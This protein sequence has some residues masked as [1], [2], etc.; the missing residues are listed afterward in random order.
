MA[1]KVSDAVLEKIREA[2]G[3]SGVSDNAEE[4]KPH[5]SEWRNRWQGETPLLI[6]PANTQEVSSV[7]RICSDTN[8]PIVPQ[9][10]NTG[11]VGGQIPTQGE[12]LLSLERMNKIREIW[13]GDNIISVEAGAVL[14]EVQAAAERAGRLFPLSLAAEGSCTIGGNLSTNAGGTNV[15]RY[16]NA[17][18]LVLGLEVVLADGAIVEMMRGLRKDN[19]GYDLKQ[20]FIGAEGTLGI[21]TAAMLKLYPKI[22][23]YT[24]VFASLSSV[25]NSVEL[26]N[27]IQTSVGNSV[28]GFELLPRFGLEL[29]LKHIP[30]TS[31][32]LRE[33]REWSVLIEVSNYAAFDPTEALEESLAQAVED[34]LV[35]DAVFAKSERERLALWRLRETMPEAQRI[36]GASISND[37][38]VRPSQMPE[39]IEKASGAVRKVFPPALPFAFGHVGD[40]NIHLAVRATERQDEALLAARGEI[41]QAVNDVVGSLGGSISAEHGL[42]LAK[43]KTIA[44]YKSS[45]EIALMKTLKSALD[46]K[47]ILNPGKVLPPG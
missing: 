44:R 6:K 39:L 43:N 9:G 28:T 32:P 12:L 34:G 25:H 16:G 2:L 36:D 38:S 8:T 19:T 1:R 23:R 29:V 41:E 30:Q 17:R 10:G 42:G 33:D 5:L 21:I 31:N 13:A 3:P 4:L 18:D 45:A 35:E 22:S 7:L 24:T 27:R 11:L 15:L 37:I 20:V 47:N 40:G 14:S 26:L 46:P